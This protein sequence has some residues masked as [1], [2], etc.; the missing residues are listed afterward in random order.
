M[1]QGN[2]NSEVEEDAK[3]NQLEIDKINENNLNENSQKISYLFYKNINNRSLIRYKIQNNFI[4]V[5]KKCSK[6]F[7]FEFSAK[8]IFVFCLSCKSELKLEKINFLE[9]N[10]NL[11]LKNKFDNNI[12]KLSKYYVGTLVWEIRKDTKVYLGVKQLEKDFKILEEK[13]LN[14]IFKENFIS[15][16]FYYQELKN[17]ITSSDYFNLYIQSNLNNLNLDDLYIIYFNIFKNLF[18]ND[19]LFRYLFIEIN[20]LKV[21]EVIIKREFRKNDIENNIDYNDIDFYSKI[22]GYNSTKNV[23]E[24]KNHNSISNFYKK[25]NLI[26]RNIF[27]N[28][29]NP[30]KELNKNL[31]EDKEQVKELIDDLNLCLPENNENDEDSFDESDLRNDSKILNDSKFVNIINND[32]LNNENDENDKNKD[33]NEKNNAYTLFNENDASMKIENIIFDPNLI[34]DKINNQVKNHINLSRSNEMRD[35]ELKKIDIN[36]KLTVT[37]IDNLSINLK[38]DLISDMTK[39]ENQHIIQ[40][41][42]KNYENLKSNEAYVYD[43]NDISWKNKNDCYSISRRNF[44]N[45]MFN[46]QKKFSEEEFEYL[47]KLDQM[48]YKRKLRIYGFKEEIIKSI[49]EKSISIIVSEPGSGKT[50]QIVQYCLNIKLNSF[51]SNKPIWCTQ[52]RKISCVNV[53]ERVSEEINDFDY[54]LVKTLLKNNYQVIKEKRKNFHEIELSHSSKLEDQDLTKIK[55]NHIKSD[56]KEFNKDSDIKNKYVTKKNIIKE[57][58]NYRKNNFIKDPYLKIDNIEPDTKIIFSTENVLLNEIIEDPYLL[59]IDILIIDEAHE[60]SLNLD[61]ILYFL[62]NYTL[63]RNDFKLIITSATLNYKQFFNYFNDFDINIINQIEKDYMILQETLTNYDKI[64]IDKIDID[65]IDHLKNKNFH[66]NCIYSNEEIDFYNLHTKTLN[67]LSSLLNNKLKVIEAKAKYNFKNKTEMEF[68]KESNEYSNKIENKIVD[69]NVR[70][71]KNNF[72][73]ILVFLPDTKSILHLKNFLTYEFFNFIEKG[74]LFIFQ[75]FGSLDFYEQSQII[76]FYCENSIKL[77][78]S[79]NISET[80]LT[81]PYCNIVVDTGL[82]KIRRY[83]Y[84]TKLLEDKIELISKDSA[85]QRQGRCGRIDQGDCYKLYTKEQFDSMSEFRIAEVSR[86][87]ISYMVLKLIYFGIPNVFKVVLIEQPNKEDIYHSIKELIVL[88]AIKKNCKNYKNKHIPADDYNEN[89]EMKIENNFFKSNN[90]EYG[91]CKNDHHDENENYETTEFGN[92]L[93]KI[94]LE[95]QFG[96][97]LYDCINC[98]KIGLNE[99]LLIIS[100]ITVGDRLI[101]NKRGTINKNSEI[102]SFIETSS[103]DVGEIINNYTYS[104][105]NNSYNRNKISSHKINFNVYNENKEEMNIFNKDGKEE[106]KGKLETGITSEIIDECLKEKTRKYIECIVENIFADI[107]L[108]Y[109][110]EE[111]LIDIKKSPQNNYPLEIDVFT[112]NTPNEKISKNNQTGKCG[113]LIEICS[114]DSKYIQQDQNKEPIKLKENQKISKYCLERIIKNN[115]YI[116]SCNSLIRYYEIYKILRNYFHPDN[117][118]LEN[119]ISSLGDMMI[120][121]FCIRQFQKMSCINHFKI[122]FQKKNFHHLNIDEIPKRTQRGY[123]CKNCIKSK[124]KF[125]RNFN[126]DLRS[127]NMLI[128]NYKNLKKILE[129]FYKCQFRFIGP[130]IYGLDIYCAELEYSICY[131]NSI[132]NMLF[133]ENYKNVFDNYKLNVDMVLENLRKIDFKKIFFDLYVKYRDIYIKVIGPSF[134]KVFCHNISFKPF[135]VFYENNKRKRLNISHELNETYLHINN[136]IKCKLEKRSIYKRYFSFL[137]W[138]KESD[139]YINNKEIDEFNF[140]VFSIHIHNLNDVILKNVNPVFPCML[141]NFK[142]EII[143]ELKKFYL[144]NGLHI[145]SISNIGPY[146]KNF[147]FEC[148]RNFEKSQYHSESDKSNN[149]LTKMISNNLNGNKNSINFLTEISSFSKDQNFILKLIENEKKNLEENYI[150]EIGYLNQDCLILK[151]K[152]GFQIVNIEFNKDPIHYKVIF[153]SDFKSLQN[154][155]NTLKSNNYKFNKIYFYKNNIFISFK[156]SNQASVF[157][158]TLKSDFELYENFTLVKIKE[159]MIY[160]NDDDN[161]NNRNILSVMVDREIN[162]EKILNKIS[163]FGE[164][165]DIIVKNINKCIHINFIM[166]SKFD[167][168]NILT[169]FKSHEDENGLWSDVKLINRNFDIY[170][171]RKFFISN[172]LFWEEL[173]QFSKENF[174][175]YTRISN[176]KIIIRNFT[177]DNIRKILG[178]LAEDVIFLCDFS[179]MEIK[180]NV[181]DCFHK[182]MGL[183][184]KEFC[185]HTKVYLEFFHYMKK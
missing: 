155:D 52:P 172:Q 33:I 25:K 120:G 68:N 121:L 88:G 128:A 107:V 85:Y 13:Y 134:F 132:Y 174:I 117:Y 83:N 104:D 131:W 90:K 62:K 168:N 123:Y 54:R 19:Y 109:E 78:L 56:L 177:D 50:T 114:S 130:E 92:W 118:F 35:D 100:C 69:E 7:K 91:K 46:N 29:E 74:S 8:Y 1:Y 141:K 178:F 6:K 41:L 39:F 105:N 20:Y 125:T 14:L 101:S 160:S 70:K 156:N 60:R 112:N 24:G 151:I 136:E 164:V 169:K 53:S 142:N 137:D 15:V 162:N 95:P 165:K 145:F 76:S 97:V 182:K 4:C 3:T 113:K 22:N 27:N 75:L 143:S 103:F 28:Q 94:E 61:I 149:P 173:D 51:I 175:E 31:L 183:T 72:L 124:Y 44:I 127:L 98:Y 48:Q 122:I 147:L 59:K 146:I 110:L 34:H 65:K 57:N 71:G 5:N 179:L 153:Q 40:N 84:D 159:D 43:N 11:D 2:E 181:A 111:E 9:N 58:T 139:L 102:P 82:H 16:Y 23:L 10:L 17:K 64:D 157:L 89:D 36:N 80:S 12:D 38:K 55:I 140:I 115:N 166:S 42:N 86:V 87:N 77:I 126:F 66:I 176:Y 49:I 73:T 47:I 167:T 106:K 133:L 21:N 99:I 81:I 170:I 93:Y 26:Y 144:S 184:F 18:D 180:F 129:L 108:S 116:D 135:I 67:F 32:E 161:Q 150:E 45:F 37:K 96:R 148:K 63:K 154:F 185:N 158:Q 152:H 138:K 79:T 171:D 163:Q 119:Q 30:Y